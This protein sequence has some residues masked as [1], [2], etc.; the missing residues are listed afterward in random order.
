[1]PNYPKAFYRFNATPI[2]IAMAFFT[3]IENL[4]ICMEPQTPQKSQSNLENAGSVNMS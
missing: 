1:M 3:E 2:K 4:K